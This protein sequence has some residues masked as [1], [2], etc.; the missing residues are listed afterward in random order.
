LPDA[1]SLAIMEHMP[2]HTATPTHQVVKQNVATGGRVSRVSPIEHFD[3][4]TARSEAA[5]RNERENR[6]HRNVI[7][8]VRPVPR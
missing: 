6:E 4:H 2:E 7:W 3:V 5:R 8:T 1:D